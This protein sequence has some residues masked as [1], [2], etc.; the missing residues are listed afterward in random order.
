MTEKHKNEII[1]YVLAKYKVCCI[2]YANI[3]KYCIK[4]FIFV[5]L[6]STVQYSISQKLLIKKKINFGL[7]IVE[8]DIWYHAC[9]TQEKKIQN[10]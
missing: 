5:T 2:T 4:C 10:W 3:I 7:L 1:A 6:F 9:C 8:V